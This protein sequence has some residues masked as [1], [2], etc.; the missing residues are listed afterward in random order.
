MGSVYLAN[1]STCGFYRRVGVGSTRI[2]HAKKQRMFP[3]ICNVCNTLVQANIW[4]EP[5]ICS[6]CQTTD[7]LIYGDRTRHPADTAHYRDHMDGKHLCPHCKNHALAFE[8]SW[9][10]TD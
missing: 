7:I 2:E 6:T 1:C 10:I 3:A 4:K 5:F 9:V 8:D